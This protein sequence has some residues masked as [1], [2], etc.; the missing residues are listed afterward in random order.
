MKI[1]TDFVTNSSST[2]F[3]IWKDKIPT[4]NEEQRAK[5]VEFKITNELDIDEMEDA[6]TIHI[7]DR[8]DEHHDEKVDELLKKL[9]A[10]AE[11]GEVEYD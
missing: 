7:C 3:T 2:S 9:G 1:K 5:L 8:N 10:L 4:M 11:V 6:L